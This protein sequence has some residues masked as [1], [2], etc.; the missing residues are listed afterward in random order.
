MCASHDIGKMSAP[1][2]AKCPSWTSDHGLAHLIDRWRLSKIRHE[3][4]SQATISDI[5]DERGLSITSAQII[6][7]HHGRWQTNDPGEIDIAEARA[8]FKAQRQALVDLLESEFGRLPEEEFSSTRA[9]YLAG[10]VAIADWIASSELFFPYHDNYPPEV[11]ASLAAEAVARIGLIPQPFISDLSFEQCF[12]FEPNPLQKT[13]GELPLDPGLYLIEADTGSGKTEAALYLAYR[14]I[15]AGL[16]RGLYFALPT[17]LTSTMILKRV[18]KALLRFSTFQHAV[19]LCHGNAWLEQPNFRPQF[20]PG[21][22]PSAA[23]AFRWF[24][25]SQLAS[26]LR[27][28]PG[29]WIKLCWQRSEPL[30]TARCARSVSPEKP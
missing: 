26:W 3:F 28:V 13:I 2:L 21:S 6:G 17:Q 8:F 15:S 20:R 25:A 27:S 29:H 30:N 16:A 11:C 14:L 9:R 18:Q 7:A 4:F 23:D 22:E 10:A 12:D 1:F 24:S 5:L 19:R